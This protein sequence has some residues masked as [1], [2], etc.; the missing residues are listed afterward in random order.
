M[1]LELSIIFPA[2]NEAQ[3]LHRYSSEV[4]PVLD[5]LGVPYEVLIVDDGSSDDTVTVAQSLG[6]RVRVVSHERNLG[7]GAALRTGFRHARGRLLITMDSDLTFAPTLIPELLERYRRGDVDTVLG[8]PKLAGYG[9]EIPSYR[10]VISQLATFV[11]SLLLQSHVTAVSPIFRLYQ[12]ADLEALELTA[13]G[14]D[15][16]AEILFG[17]LRSG[18]RVVEIPA[19]L[20][21]RI[22]GASNLQYRREILRHCRL[23]M[24]MLTWRIASLAGS[25]R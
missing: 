14:F 2:L 25:R 4:F 17:L 8:S 9:S 16:N 23:V 12:R 21:A 18:K 5:G 7:L 22:H 15:I 3:N 20:T 19:P 13:A 6:A 1:E 11:Y 10:I 24:K